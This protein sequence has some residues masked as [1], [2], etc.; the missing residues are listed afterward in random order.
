IHRVLPH[1]QCDP[2]MAITQRQI[3]L[4]ANVSRS[5]VAAILANRSAER[6]SGEVRDRVL[7]IA[8]RNGYRPNRYAQIISNGKSGYIGVLGF[9]TSRALPFQ[10]LKIAT[11][12]FQ[13][14]NYDLFVQE[15]AWYGDA[16]ERVADLLVQKLLDAQVEGVLLS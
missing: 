1:S 16:P 5:T 12:I 11:G 6:F 10:K 15:A 14:S 9:G 2:S 4:E 3:A 7:E 8:R 13:R